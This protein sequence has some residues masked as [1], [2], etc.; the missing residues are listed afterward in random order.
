MS[1]M[2]HD[3]ARKE[4]RTDALLASWK[5]FQLGLSEGGYTFKFYINAAFS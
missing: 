3:C 1:G 4:M 5:I 2:I